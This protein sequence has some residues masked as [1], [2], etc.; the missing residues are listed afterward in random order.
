MKPDDAAARSCSIFVERSSSKTE[1]ATTSVMV[2]LGCTQCLMYVMSSK[3]DLKCPK[4]NN[5]TLL[6]VHN[7]ANQASKKNLVDM[8]IDVAK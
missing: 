7:L 8:S 2:L 5:T 6:D 1:D 3:F 4:C